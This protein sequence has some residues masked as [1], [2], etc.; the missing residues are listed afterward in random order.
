MDQPTTRPSLL[1]RLR[2]PGDERAWSEF[3]AI[4]A[5]LV[6]RLARHKG[7]QDADAR[8]LTQEVFA[9]V[10]RAFE[11]GAFE[12]GKGSFRGWLFRIA[13]NLTVNFLVRQGRHPRGSGD[14]DLHDLLD[15]HAA[16][17]AED[18]ALFDAEY[19]RQ[20][21]CWAIEEVR[22]EFTELTWRAFWQAGVEGRPAPEVARE[23][24]TTVGTVYHCKSRVM[25]RL[26]AKVQ[27]VE[28]EG[29]LPR[30]P[31]PC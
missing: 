17:G 18:S 15:A 23:L 22:G 2:D 13:R 27:E 14:S 19:K 8:D 10:V 5:P 20:L 26:R 21:L 7:L 6:Y 24:Q 25:A 11:S 30:E 31:A 1:L 9:A 16:P 3:A 12:E 29:G 4:Y 28:G